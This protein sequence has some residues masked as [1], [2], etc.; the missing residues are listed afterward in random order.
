MVWEEPTI[1]KKALRSQ[2]FQKSAYPHFGD[3]GFPSQHV[4]CETIELEKTL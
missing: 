3:N 1:F 4:S 2:F